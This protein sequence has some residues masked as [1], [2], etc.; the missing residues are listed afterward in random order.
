MSLV[1]SPAEQFAYEGCAWPE[2]Q[3]RCEEV[4]ASKAE[5]QEQTLALIF[6]L[7]LAPS[8]HTCTV[9]V[10]TKWLHENL[11][12]RAFWWGGGV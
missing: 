4:P 7:S 11:G 1:R 8:R 6:A 10:S 3:P 9:G 2:A 12:M 5:D